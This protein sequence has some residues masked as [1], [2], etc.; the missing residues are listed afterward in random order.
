[1][2]NVTPQSPLHPG[3]GVL[4]IGNV[5]P[6]AFPMLVLVNR[7]W[8]LLKDLRAVLVVKD[9]AVAFTKLL[10]DVSIARKGA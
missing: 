9:F 6:Y 7:A 3:C 1:M 2:V 4:F 5:S 10:R 8:T